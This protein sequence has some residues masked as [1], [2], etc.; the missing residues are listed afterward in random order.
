MRSLIGVPLLLA[1]ALVGASPAWA[2]DKDDKKEKSEE[3]EEDDKL[4]APGEAGPDEDDFKEEDEED[5]APPPKR[6]D[7]GD[8]EE[9]GEDN[10]DDID[11]SDTGDDDEID[12]KD[13]S[14]QET[15]A[16]RGPGE[17]TAQLYRDQQK[18]CQE[19]NPDEEQIAW[20]EYLK[21]YPKSLFKDRIETRMEE[22]SNLMF[23]ERVEGSDKGANP[24]RDAALRELNFATPMS[25][26]S[27]DPRSK[28]TAGVELGLPN[29]F[30]GN[31]DLEWGIKRNW[32]VHGGL[33]RGFAGG[34][35]VAGTKYSLVKSSRT[36][37]IL[38]G[39]VDLNLNMGPAFLALDPWVGFGQR[40]RMLDGLDLQ[41][42]L[43]VP[44]ELREVFVP[45]LSTNFSA[46]LHA[47][48]TV[49]VFLNTNIDAKYLGGADTP[50]FKFMTGAL[51]LKFTGAK[52]KGVDK[53]GRLLID[54]GAN[55]PY[56][57]AYW[58]F[59]RGAI[60]VGGEYYF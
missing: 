48:Q 1:F 52:G 43:G 25:F 44:L 59:Y 15:V 54:V 55:A 33:G 32:S 50:T 40:I 56:N 51:G 29:W 20:E 7:E 31:L 21:K 37:S 35:V 3:E 19:M 57:H 2:K 41:L 23:S 11:F 24:D 8:T 38:T 60:D 58:G 53:N 42:N 4:G 36:G 17:D 5:D 27:V 47:N 16:A 26:R 28:I 39:G 10:S 18:K 12:F 13:D 22:L 14:E 6:L 9:P 34:E 45:R 49:S 30:G 46:E